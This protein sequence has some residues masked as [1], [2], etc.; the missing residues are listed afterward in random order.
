MTELFDLS[1]RT[2]LIT[3]ASSGFGADFSRVLARAGA[4]V[5]LGARRTDRLEELADELRAA[6]HAALAVKLDV[7]APD[8]VAAAYHSAEAEFGVVDVVVNNAGLNRS[9]WLT[10]LSESDWDAVQEVNL[11]A[12]W[13]V[14]R[15]GARRLQAAGQPGSV[16][17]VASVLATGTSKRLGVYMATKAAVVQLTKAMALEWAGDNIRANALAPGYFPTEMTGDYFATPAGKAMIERIPMGRVGA[18]PELA[19]PLLLLASDASAY[20]TGS[21]ITVDGG[22][23]CHTL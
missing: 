4:R 10:E 11:K 23:L 14:A 19:G 18:L 16:I 15:E 17:N 7:T 20:M 2:A 12:V 3:G 22:H 9:A 6:G 5:V 13:R 8:S 1:G 21:V